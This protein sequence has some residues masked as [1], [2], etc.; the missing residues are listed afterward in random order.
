MLTLTGGLELDATLTVAGQE[1][2][3]Q[4]YGDANLQ[5]DGTTFH[6]PP[7]PARST[8]GMAAPATVVLYP[9]SNSSE[10][11][12][13][14][15]LG[16]GVTLQGQGTIGNWYGESYYYYNSQLVNQGT[17]AVATAGQALTINSNLENTGQLLVGDKTT[18]TL[19]GEFTLADLQGLTV[20][21]SGVVLFTGTLDNTGATLEFDELPAALVYNGGQ[22]LD[23]TFVTG[24]G[25]FT[26]PSAA[27]LVLDGVSRS[28]GP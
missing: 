17:I 21:G 10:S 12:A 6:H 7:A 9:N 26:L 25:P 1:T 14:V 8:W 15:T 5:F 23:G 2:S 16:P 18:L 13:V 22:I 11:P 3:G 19:G 4:N 27:K 24:S 20:S 28:T